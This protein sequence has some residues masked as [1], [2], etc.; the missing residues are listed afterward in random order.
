MVGGSTDRRLPSDLSYD[1][2][3]LTSRSTKMFYVAVDEMFNVVA[4]DNVF[5]IVN[6]AVREPV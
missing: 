4:D 2:T 1:L 5:N 6:E 3:V